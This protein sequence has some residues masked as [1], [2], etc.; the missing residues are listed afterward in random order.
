GTFLAGVFFWPEGDTSQECFDQL[1][2]GMPYP[3][4]ERIIQAHGFVLAG[5]D[6]GHGE[7]LMVF[8]RAGCKKILI[9]VSITGGVYHKEL[10][11]VPETESWVSALWRRLVGPAAK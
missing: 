5:G 4:A 1:Q 10:G 7:A 2:V 9:C 11:E 3:E 6:V 8:K